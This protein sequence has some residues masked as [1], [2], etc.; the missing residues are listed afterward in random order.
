MGGSGRVSVN[1]R[2]GKPTTRSVPR[3][4]LGWIRRS[5]PES[6]AGGPSGVE[7]DPL[8]LAG[9]R[10][11]EQREAR[12]LNLRE[13]AEETRIST[14]VLEALERGWRD[15]LP[16][17]TYLRT[18]LPLIERYLALPPGSLDA[19]LPAP[20]HEARPSSRR[21][22][23]QR[24]TPGS[25][26]V[27][28]T[29][30]GTVLYGLLTLGLV[31]AVNLQQQRLA[32][33]GLLSSRPI[34]PLPRSEQV[35]PQDPAAQLL[36]IHPELRPLKVTASGQGLPQ[37]RRELAKGSPE[38]LGVLSL[39]LA[40]SSRVEISPSQG[41]NTRLEGVNG[42]IS[43]PIL[44]P[45][46]LRIE[47]AT[48]AR[49][50]RWNGAPLTPLAGNPGGRFRYPAVIAAPPAPKRPAATVAQPAP[51]GPTGEERP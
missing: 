5:P 51:P 31:Y 32:A 6:A 37:L 23:L 20:A 2:P 10:L 22:L 46:E 4:L 39:E 15:R 7:Q 29:W 48:A 50:V 8:L 27:F 36:A 38:A 16:E 1:L 28:T 19:A 41:G 49:A 24:F 34:P 25:I 11:R 13:L 3:R 12:G 33:E 44:P 47:P 40:S 43:L 21:M 9:R 17:V 26:D 45:F 30:Q 14:P 18:M 42:T 35:R